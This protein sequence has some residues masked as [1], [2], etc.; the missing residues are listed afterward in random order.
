MPN[1][2]KVD[3]VDYFVVPIILVTVQILGLTTVTCKR[4]QQDVLKTLR[5]LKLTRIMKEQ[6]IIRPRVLHQPVH[7]PDYILFRWLTHGI[8]LVIRQ[9]HHVLPFVAKVTIQVA[10]QVLD[11]VDTSPQR[12]LLAKIVDADQ[13]SFPSA[14]TIRILK[15]IALR[16]AVSENL[17][18]LGWRGRGAVALRLLIAARRPSI[19]GRWRSTVPI[20]LWWWRRALTRSVSGQSKR[21]ELRQTYLLILVVLL[22]WWWCSVTTPVAGLWAW[23]AIPLRVMVVRH[24]SEI[25]ALLDFAGLH[26]LV[27][28]TL[29]EDSVDFRRDI[30]TLDR[31][32][33]WGSVSDDRCLYVRILLEGLGTPASQDFVRVARSTAKDSSSKGSRSITSRRSCIRS[34]CGGGGAARPRTPR[35]SAPPQFVTCELWLASDFTSCV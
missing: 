14:S 22:G 25:I 24:T 31:P 18:L 9:N 20:L 2:S 33:R 19:L 32:C 23:C 8:L 7:R 28:G 21:G 5:D 12:A 26:T 30:L 13:Q 34:L 1:L 16:S 29:V 6:R 3:W 10:R 35:P 17:H 15:L 11:I 4:S 27:E